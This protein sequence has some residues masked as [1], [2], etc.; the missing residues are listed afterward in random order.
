MRSPIRLSVVAVAAA[1]LGFL[2]ANV[3]AFELQASSLRAGLDRQQAIGV[4]AA[5][6]APLR[7]ALAARLTAAAPFTTLAIARDP[8]ADLKAA[9]HDVLRSSTQ[10]SQQRASDALSHLAGLRGGPDSEYAAERQALG[11]AG[12]PAELDLLADR[13]TVAAETAELDR[14]TLGEIAGGLTPEGRPAD[15]VDYVPQLESAIADAAQAQVADD[16]APAARDALVASWALPVDVQL[17][18]HEDL[19]AS[20]ASALDMVTKRAQAKRHAL[21]LAGGIDDLLEQATTIGVSDDLR[22]QATRG[23]DAAPAAH[24]EAEVHAA[25]SDLE[26][27]TNALTAIVDRSPEAPLPP[28]L[29][30][31]AASQVIWIHLAT[32]QLIAYQDG[33]PWLGTQVTTG[34]PALPTDRG[35]FRIFYKA[36]AYK[37]ISP[38]PKGSPFWYP[39]AWVYDAMEFVGDGTFIHNADWQPDDT[40]GPGSEYGPYA[41][42][43]C[44]HVPDAALAKLYDWA[45]LGATV[46]VGD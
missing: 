40:Y 12:T 6:L 3:A 4:P 10:R 21:D 15:L 38:W 29:P 24:T 19:R 2:G 33:C 5:D 22:A 44:V 36:P 26:Q 45:Q 16:P 42:H 7:A 39:D 18:Q 30:A 20:A 31:G 1:I 13:W 28:C 32:Q 35:T 9:A 23:R 41:S 11:A 14:R 25:V 34:R 46:I 43:G 8:F 17:A 37:M 27:A